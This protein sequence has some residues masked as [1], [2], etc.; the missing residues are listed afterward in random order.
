[1]KKIKNLLFVLIIGLLFLPIGLILSAE[2]AMPAFSGGSHSTDGCHNDLVPL[3]AVGTVNLTSSVNGSVN[4]GTDFTISA[5]IRNFTEASSEVVPLGFSSSRGDNGD[6]TF[7]PSYKADIGL[8]TTGHT[9]TIQNFTVTA[10]TTGGNYTITADALYDLDGDTGLNY[11]WGSINITVEGSSNGGPL[12]DDPPPLPPLLVLAGTI[13][14]LS[15][16]GVQIF[17]TA[18]FLLKGKNGKKSDQK[19]KSK[20]VKG[21]DQE[22]NQVKGVTAKNE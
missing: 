17:L 21:R 12:D 8:N 15:I 2:D 6:F 11:A 4:G 7:A 3:S 9:T 5:W 22:L 13:G 19:P 20:K 14:G 1:M 16:L 18:K 10:P